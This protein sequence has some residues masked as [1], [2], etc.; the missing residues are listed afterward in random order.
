MNC[1]NRK[2]EKTTLYHEHELLESNL[3]TQRRD[4][5]LQQQIFITL[6]NIAYLI[7]GQHIKYWESYI[8]I[9]GDFQ[10]DL[11]LMLQMHSRKA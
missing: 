11:L 5:W 2:L 6:V 3:I 10:S 8:C 9:Y 1:G 4:K 7:N